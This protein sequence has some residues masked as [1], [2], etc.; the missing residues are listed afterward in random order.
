[1]AYFRCPTCKESLGNKRIVF[2]DTMKK[3][4]NK[5]TN[6]KEQKEKRKKRLKNY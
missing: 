3:I 2:D 4:N 6:T 1:M 5:P